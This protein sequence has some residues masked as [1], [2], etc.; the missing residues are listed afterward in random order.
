MARKRRKID[1]P[2]A[3][4]DRWLISYADFITLL[5][6]FFVVM[7]AIS[8]VNEGKYRVLSETLGAVFADSGAKAGGEPPPAI[9]QGGESLLP[10]HAVAAGLPLPIPGV[11]VHAPLLNTDMGHSGSD[12]GVPFSDMLNQLR[13]SLADFTAKGLVSVSADGDRV[14]VQ[15][16]SQLLFDSGDAR[17]SSQAL[18]ALHA[19]GQVL[20]G[21]PYPVRVEGHT[22]NMPI[23]TPQ[24]PSNWELSAARAASV[25][26]YLT[27]L[28][29]APGRM[30]AVGYGEYRPKAS[31][32]TEA[33]RAQN[34]RVTLVISA[35][36]DPAA[37]AADAVPWA[38]GPG[39]E[40]Q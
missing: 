20:D 33:G 40:G 26:N 9:P 13:V 18:T 2:H 37:A 29:I 30:A 28:G 10:E 21:S 31:N 24:F 15:M 39:L 6:A 36:T 12:G 3:P 19:V 7:Y 1:T 35:G 4:L 22:D 32:H 11:P 14:V 38:E 34:R 16:L 17:L 27:R 25:V 23:S 8:T 5:F